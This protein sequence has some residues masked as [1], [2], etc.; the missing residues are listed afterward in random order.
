MRLDSI[1]STTDTNVRKDSIILV[2]TKVQQDGNFVFKRE[3]RALKEDMG[4]VC[5]PPNF[6]FALTSF[7][8]Q[9]NLSANHN[10]YL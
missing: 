2:P 3:S 6:V 5:F 10:P 9:L 7:L 8:S 1:V 4:A